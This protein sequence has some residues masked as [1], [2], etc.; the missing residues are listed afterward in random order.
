ME[1]FVGWVWWGVPRFA[2]PYCPL[3]GL[4]S[5]LRAMSRSRDRVAPCCCG[6][7]GG[8]AGWRGEA[9]TEA[10]KA[11]CSIITDGNKRTGCSPR[12]FIKIRSVTAWGVIGGL[13]NP[14]RYWLK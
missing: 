7:F 9:A 3:L 5:I 2:L 4:G 10:Y 11:T 14:E 6:S 12:V 1:D 13:N 8:F